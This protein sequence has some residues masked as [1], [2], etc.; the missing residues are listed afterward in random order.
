MKGLKNSIRRALF[1]MLFSHGDRYVCVFC[2]KSYARFLGSG[3]HREAF[4]RHDVVGLY[5]HL[6]SN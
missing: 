3:V 6:V 2:G 4:A 5:A 1:L